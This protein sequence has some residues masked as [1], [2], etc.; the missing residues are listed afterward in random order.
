MRIAHCKNSVV[1]YGYP[2]GILTQVPDDM[3]G[4]SHRWLAVYYP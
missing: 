3:L 2:M 4:F 1:A